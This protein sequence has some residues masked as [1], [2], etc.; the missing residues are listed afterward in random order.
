M[1]TTKEARL[2]A[3]FRSP[4]LAGAQRESV[5]ELAAESSARVFEQ[6]ALVIRAGLPLRHILYVVEGLIALSTGDPG[7]RE[8]LLGVAEAPAFIGDEDLW[9]SGRWTVTGRALRTSLLLLIPRSVFEARVAADHGFAA[10]LYR[11]ACRRHSQI[12]MALQSR[13]TEPTDTQLLRL[14]WDL[15]QPSGVPGEIAV[16]PLSHSG[17]ARALGLDRKTVARNLRRLVARGVISVRGREVSLKTDRR[18]DVDRGPS[19]RTA[20]SWRFSAVERTRCPA[21]E[22][23]ERSR[24][25]PPVLR[26]AGQ[27]ESS[28]GVSDIVASGAGLAAAW[29][30]VLPPTGNTL[31]A[32]RRQR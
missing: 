29:S 16:A 24:N 30:R 19:A 11:E 1:E 31:A 28:A 9:G 20:C 7:A 23:Q 27:H 10:G 22:R 12:R 8:L 3:L 32:G 5:L 18:F 2:D 14:L 6:R 25:G 4:T 13:A 26:G 17:L 21:R 15:A